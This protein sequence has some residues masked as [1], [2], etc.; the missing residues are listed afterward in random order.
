MRK[1]LLG[2]VLAMALAIGSTATAVASPPTTKYH[3][4]VVGIETAK[5]VGTTSTFAG[6][7]FGELPGFWTASVV[8]S[9]PTSPVVFGAITGGRFAL[10]NSRFGVLGSFDTTGTIKMLR[11]S[12]GG[13]FCTQTFQV[14]DTLTLSAP[15]TGV[16]VPG[17]FFDAT[18][19]HYGNMV[20]V[21][22][23][24]FFATVYGKVTL[25]F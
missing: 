2:L 9:L 5:P 14:F 21:Q 17:S 16:G 1:L 23:I 19:T 24:P 18:L 11:N 15:A 4:T 8:Q 3:D 25:I 10:T 20:G 7:A 13:G 6:Y 12:A 22:C